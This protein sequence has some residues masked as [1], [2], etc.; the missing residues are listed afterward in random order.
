[1]MQPYAQTPRGKKDEI[2][3]LRFD[4]IAEGYGEIIGG[5]NVSTT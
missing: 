4:M 1:M 5:V 2:W 3:L